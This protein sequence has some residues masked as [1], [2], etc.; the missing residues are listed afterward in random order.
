ME[1]IDDEEQPE[2]TV[3]VDNPELFA[4]CWHL[5]LTYMYCVCLCESDT[6]AS[7]LFEGIA[8]VTPKPGS[9]CGRA[10]ERQ[11][12][13]QV[14]ESITVL[15]NLTSQVFVARNIVFRLMWSG[16]SVDVSVGC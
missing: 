4:M 9:D 5:V 13:A 2:A 12:L 11:G 15:G 16:A 6:V 10:A 1:V 8:K 7:Q 14:R 3:A